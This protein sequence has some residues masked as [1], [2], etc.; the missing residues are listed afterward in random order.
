MSRRR[1]QHIGTCGVAGLALAAITASGPAAA[2]EAGDAQTALVEEF[3]AAFNAREI[4]RMLALADER[5]EWL[6]VDGA[7]VAV[8]TAGR[9]ALRQSMTSYF[10]SCPS[11]RSALEWTRTAGLR[12]AALER[13]SWTT[14]AGVAKAQKSLSVYELRDGRIARVYYFPAEAAPAAAA[15]P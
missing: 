14:A 15:T 2:A 1:F 6:S 12:V 11:C 10:A 8:E 9:E 4:E 3:V 7:G 13:A 5:I